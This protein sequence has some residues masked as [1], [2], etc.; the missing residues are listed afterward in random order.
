VGY[1]FINMYFLRNLPCFVETYH[2]YE[3][4]DIQTWNQLMY[5][6][7]VDQEVS[8]GHTSSPQDLPSW[9]D[10]INTSLTLQ[11]FMTLHPTYFND[12]LRS[13]YSGRDVLTS[14]FINT[15]VNHS[16]LKSQY[17]CMS[18][19][20]LPNAIAV[21]HV[22]NQSLQYTLYDALVHMYQIYYAL[23][24]MGD[25]FTHYDVRMGNVMALDIFPG[26]EL[27][28]QFEYH[29]HPDR[30]P[31]VLRSS[32][33]IKLIDY[34]RCYIDTSRLPSPMDSS[35]YPLS[36]KQLVDDVVC[37]VKACNP[38]ATQLC[39]KKQ[40][41]SMNI[42][43]KPGMS[44][45]KGHYR[46]IQTTGYKHSDSYDQ[47]LKRNFFDLLRKVIQNNHTVPYL[48]QM[49]LLEELQRAHSIRDI[50]HALTRVLQHPTFA[51]FERKSQ[52]APWQTRYQIWFDRPFQITHA[53]AR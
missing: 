33:L 48:N 5:F 29:Y 47:V 23:Y 10:S 51:E 39:G 42:S 52:V 17:L 27:G 45:I 21:N 26:T 43:G 28:L 50:F 44:V 25:S 4:D 18:M 24:I 12:H 53:N 46:D 32:Y 7:S 15:A 49:P 38:H 14:D 20:Y 6:A 8:P 3:I 1:Y 13:L 9:D 16:C 2:L 35:S 40:G 11:Q 41:Y 37:R 19:E 34:G 31:L 36:T 30:P 22:W